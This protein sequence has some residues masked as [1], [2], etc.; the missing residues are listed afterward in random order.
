MMILKLKW[1]YLK[2]IIS[3]SYKH[4]FQIK[5]HTSVLEE[6]LINKPI[7]LCNLDLFSELYET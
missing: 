6:K 4:N 2:A 3:Y 5:F 7:N 1:T